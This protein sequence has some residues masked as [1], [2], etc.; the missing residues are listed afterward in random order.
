MMGRYKGKQE[1]LFHYNFCLEERVR[2]DHPLRKVAGLIDFDFIYEEVNDKY[3]ANGNVSVPPP[4]I[5]KL[6]LLLV[7]YNVRSERELMSTLP[8]RL[9]WLWFLGYDLDSDI[10]DHSVLSK[11]RKRWGVEAFK[12]FFERIVWQCVEAE[13]VDGKKIFM[14]SSLVDADASTN[15]VIDTEKLKH[16]LKRNYKQLEAR[17]EEKDTGPHSQ[18]NKR[19]ISSTDPDAAIVRRGKPKLR[20]QVHRAVDGENEIITAT[21]TTPG[22]MNEAHEMV[23]LIDQ[24]EEL[25]EA[26]IDTVVADSKYGTIENFLTCHDRGIDGHMPDFYQ[27]SGRRKKQKIFTEDKFQYDPKNDIY[28]C[29]AGKPMKRKTLHKK[30]QSIDYAA[31]KKNCDVCKLRG[32]CTKNKMGRTIKRHLRQEELDQMRL[33]SSSPTAKRDIKTRQHLMERSFARG[34][35]LGI[36]R[37]R[38][39]G[40]WRMEIQEYLTCAIQNIQVLISRSGPKKEAAV[41]VVKVQVKKVTPWVAKINDPPFWETAFEVFNRMMTN[42]QSYWRILVVLNSIRSHRLEVF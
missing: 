36:K 12:T 24:H 28:I 1:R 21:S 3:G 13:L 23:T 2:S 10:P 31:S 27:A 25:T 19:Y 42:F 11:A 17:L 33:A 35:R 20:Y 40:L 26:A 5:L 32:Q 16:Q 22:D 30:R 4:V 8:E 37:A 38:W 39:R 34:E 41:N 7:F 9:D 6:M 15:S 18:V 29:P 14:D